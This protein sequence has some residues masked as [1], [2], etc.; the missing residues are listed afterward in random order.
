MT[1]EKRLKE[2]VKKK[3]PTAGLCWRLQKQVLEAQQARLEKWLKELEGLTQVQIE[4]KINKW[5]AE[6]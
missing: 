5:E 4:Y 6:V 3:F 1:V 2:I